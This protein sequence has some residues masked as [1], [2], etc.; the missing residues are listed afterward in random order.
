MLDEVILCEEV[1]HNP[2]GVAF[3]DL[4][5]EG[6]RETWPIR[7]KRF[8][9]W[10]RRCYYRATGAAPNGTVVTSAL[11]LLEARAQFDAPERAVSMRV[12]EYAGRIYLD[13]ADEHWRAVAIGA[14][15]WRVIGCPPVRFRRS[16]GILPLP[17]PERGGS[18]EILRPFPNLSSQN[19]FVLVVAWLLAALRPHGPYP[20]LAISGEQG[21]AKTVL[22]KVL[23]ALV[24]PNVAPIRA[25]PRDE[26]ELMIAANNGHV[27]AFDNLSGLPPWLSDALCRIASGGSFTVRRLYSDDEEVLFQAARPIILNGIEDV[28]SR[29]DLAD[30][31]I[32]LSLP[33]IEEEQRRSEAGLWREFEKTR[34][35]ILGAL[36]DA[37]VHGL[38]AV[39][40]VH[41][42]RLPR[43]ADF[44]LWATA[45]E[46]RFW[47]AG[48]FSRVYASNRKAAIQGIIDADPIATYVRELMSERMSWRGCAADLL[49][50]VE[51][52]SQSS[53]GANWPRNPRALASR[54]RRSQTLLRA[55]GID[56]AFGRE[57]RAGRRIISMRSC[58]E[59]T[60]GTVSTVSRVSEKAARSS[61]GPSLT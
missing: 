41:P 15:G 19:D 37:V 12:A 39:D 32:F 53:Y 2:G 33:P 44:A 51:R 21:S 45:C 4:I 26:R 14:D 49:Q 31:A 61:A 24:D 56:I 40:S 11:D 36:L 43:M 35:T 58:C 28:I 57:G 13:L 5:T 60:V 17:V 52:T 29:A 46:S 38:R 22:S 48:T 18:I 59:E 6:H 54:L 27:L 30:R 9:S 23:R 7:S 3:A 34:P 42:S 16:P 50:G 55:I 10:V 1:F 20:L 25:L 47:P 8:R